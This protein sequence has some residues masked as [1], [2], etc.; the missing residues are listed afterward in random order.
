MVATSSYFCQVVVYYFISLGIN[1]YEDAKNSKFLWISF[2]L[3]FITCITNDSENHRAVKHCTISVDASEDS[4]EQHCYLR[5]SFFAAWYYFSLTCNGFRIESVGF[6]QM[7]CIG[8]YLCA[9]CKEVIELLQSSGLIRESCSC[10]SEE[11]II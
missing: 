8:S 11:S 6:L 4:R 1:L 2:Y 9:N 10:E 3:S 7:V 5:N